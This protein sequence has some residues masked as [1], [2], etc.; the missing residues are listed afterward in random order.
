LEITKFSLFKSDIYI[1][2]L[3]PVSL[4]WRHIAP[5]QSASSSLAL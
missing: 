2:P 3:V 5:P 4:D 1:D